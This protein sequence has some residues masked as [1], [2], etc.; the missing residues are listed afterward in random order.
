MRIIIGTLQIGLA[1]IS[2][3]M[4]DVTP[5]DYAAR[6]IVYLSRQKASRGK[7]FHVVN[8][9]P[10]YGTDLVKQLQELGYPLQVVD[11]ET[12]FEAMVDQA[13]LT[14]DE[15]LR[16]V[17]AILQNAGGFD[18]SPKYDCRNTLAALAGTDITCP[19]IDTAMLRVY[20]SYYERQGVFKTLPQT[21]S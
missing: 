15:N 14:R 16:Y 9:N 20:L 18:D 12:W 7:N 11:G 8:P 4:E 13:T 6:A 10:L 5:V 17:S 2:H 1:P 3:S 19:A 21:Q